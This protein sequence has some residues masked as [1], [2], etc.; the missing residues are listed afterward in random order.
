MAA[1]A[2]S[3]RTAIIDIETWK[4]W[5]AAG[6]MA[7]LIDVRSATEFASGHLPGAIN[8]PLEQVELRAADLATAVP[9]VLV[10]QA[11]TR[12]HLAAKLL[13]TDHTNLVVLEGGTS[14]WINAGNPAV[15]CTASRWALERQ[16]RLIAGLLVVVGV[17]LGVIVSP[18]FLGLAAFIGCGLTFAA[19][20][21]LCLMGELLARCPWNRAQYRARTRDQARTQAS[22]LTCVQ[23]STNTD[24][25]LNPGVSC[26]CESQK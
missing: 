24:A 26:A 14:A 7:Q 21:N 1:P 25:A 10:C 8:I 23:C 15:R 9:I 5:Q 12:A 3:H 6:T 13:E 20:S 17:A 4:A 19:V 16:V 2:I 18:W 11:G 22:G